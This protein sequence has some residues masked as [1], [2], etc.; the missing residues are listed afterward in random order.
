MRGHGKG[1]GEFPPATRLLSGTRSWVTVCPVP[2][3]AASRWAAGL[4]AV[5]E[6]RAL[7]P[8]TARVSAP[9]GSASEQVGESAGADG[10]QD[11]A[12]GR[13]ARRDP[14]ADPVACGRR[15]GRGCPVGRCGPTARSRRT[16]GPRP[17]RPSR[18]S[19]ARSRTGDA[20]PAGAAGR[21]GIGQPLRQSRK[22]AVLTRGRLDQTDGGRLTAHRSSARFGRAIWQVTCSNRSFVAYETG[23]LAGVTPL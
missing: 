6:P 12:D 21:P 2:V 18:R 13:R 22:G 9:A 1:N 14:G 17:A 23:R 20:S 10:V 5:R 19:A 8:S 3:I 15:G 4:V 7:L 11:A 16:S